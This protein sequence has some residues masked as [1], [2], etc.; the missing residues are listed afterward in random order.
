MSA[1]P[2]PGRHAAPSPAQ[3]G[4]ALAP[5]PPEERGSTTVADRVVQRVACAAAAE[6]R[7]TRPVSDRLGGLVGRGSSARA[8]V[9]RGGGRVALRLEIAVSYPSP[10]ARTAEEVRAHVSATVEA[11]TGLTVHSA[12]IEIVELVPAPRV[13]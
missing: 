2:G 12:D 6:H 5:A 10:L 4:T 3:A 1:V 13:R 11:L 7:S 8:E 9:R